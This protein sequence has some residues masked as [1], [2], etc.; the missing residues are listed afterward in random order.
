MKALYECFN[1]ATDHHN[2]TSVVQCAVSKPSM[3]KHESTTFGSS[4]LG[5]DLCT[6]CGA[7]LHVISGVTGVRLLRLVPVVGGLYLD[8]LT[9]TKTLQMTCR[10][11]TQIALRGSQNLRRKFVLVCLFWASVEDLTKDTF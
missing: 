9:T 2:C 1:L 7:R 11:S 10:A 3:N 8:T 6:F 5:M 4:L